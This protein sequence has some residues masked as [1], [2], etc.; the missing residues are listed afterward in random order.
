MR[1]LTH[2]P[3][4]PFLSPCPGILLTGASS[5]HRASSLSNAWQGHPLLHVQL[6]PWVPPCI[7]FGWWFS[8]WEL[9]VAL[10]GRYYRSSY[11]VENPSASSVLSLTPPLGTP[12][13]VQWLAASIPICIGQALTEPLRRQLCQAPVSKH[14]LASTKGS[15]F[16]VCIWDGSPGGAVSGWPFL[17]SL[18]YFLSLYFL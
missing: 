4:H 10:V 1:V 8:P 2:P 16:R 11:G 7:L 9:W 17:Q 3:T 12:C 15:E 18:L 13:S 5:L 6:E 14:F